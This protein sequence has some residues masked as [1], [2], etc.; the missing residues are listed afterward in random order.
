MF[1]GA[2]AA[3]TVL[4]LLIVTVVLYIAAFRVPDGWAQS[5]LYGLV[6]LPASALGS[7]FYRRYRATLSP[8][9]VRNS[10]A[11]EIISV[12]RDAPKMAG[13][14]RN[15]TDKGIRDAL[16][17]IV[18]EKLL[19]SDSGGLEQKANKVV[20][21]RWYQK[22]LAIFLLGFLLGVASFG[23]VVSGVIWFLY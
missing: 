9:E 20:A 13:R 6:A 3:P 21:L 17:E 2:F 19:E 15:N 1:L 4:F 16:L 7:E 8:T 18:A 11:A 12:I 23:A 5:M 14:K 22:S 10:F